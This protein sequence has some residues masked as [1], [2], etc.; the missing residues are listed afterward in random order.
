MTEPASLLSFQS[1]LLIVHLSE[2]QITS[3]NTTSIEE[4]SM[5]EAGKSDTAASCGSIGG[6]FNHAFEDARIQDLE[7]QSS[8]LIRD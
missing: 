6:I 4:D 3:T 5:H 2:A 8:L 1:C 7:T